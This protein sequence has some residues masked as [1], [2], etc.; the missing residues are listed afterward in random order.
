MFR[1]FLG[2][3]NQNKNKVT[4]DNQS[5]TMATNAKSL[6]NITKIQNCLTLNLV[7]VHLD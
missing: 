2:E 5:V 3:Q 7:H 1:T 4:N 6:R